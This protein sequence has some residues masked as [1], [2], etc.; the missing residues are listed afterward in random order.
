MIRAIKGIPAYDIKEVLHPA[1]RRTEKLEKL[2][3]NLRNL[4][5]LLLI[6][7]LVHFEDLIVD[8]D[9]G[10]NGRD[11]ELCKP[12]L[13]LFHG[14]KS[15]NMI[16]TAIKSF[17]IKKNTRRNNVSL[18]PILFSII[19]NMIPKYGTTISV[20]EIWDKIRE[21]VNGVYNP[22]KPNEYQTFDYDTIYRSTITRILEGFGAERKRKN[23]GM[24]LIFDKGKLDKIGR[25]YPVGEE[26]VKGEGFP[27]YRRDIYCWA[28]CFSSSHKNENQKD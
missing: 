12:L 26:E 18:E 20:K 14:T 8:S 19:K 17:L 24:V 13:Q 1:S 5:K 21:D 22:E 6:Y 7:R 27:Y 3:N 4:R 25:M 23:S 11:K 28:I 15:Y 2:H 16:A 9:I 10:L